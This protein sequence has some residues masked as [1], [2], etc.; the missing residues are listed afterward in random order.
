MRNLFFCIVLAIARVVTA[1]EPDNVALIPEEKKTGSH[2]R[3]RYIRSAFA[4][5]YN[6]VM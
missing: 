1:T 6:T 4:D 2:I 5:F 3:G